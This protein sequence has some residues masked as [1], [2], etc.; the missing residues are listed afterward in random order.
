MVDL[1]GTT[2]ALVGASIGS[3]YV[4]FS[5]LGLTQMGTIPLLN[6]RVADVKISP[7]DKV[8]L[9]TGY[10]FTAAVSM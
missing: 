8:R 2:Y 7:A 1:T 3:S 4:L 10:F 5:N 9:W 6:G